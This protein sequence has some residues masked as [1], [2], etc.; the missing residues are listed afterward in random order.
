MSGFTADAATDSLDEYPFEWPVP[1]G[2]TEIPQW[3]GGCFRVGQRKMR[4]L[5]YLPH[6]VNDKGWNDEFAS[7]M[8]QEDSRQKSIAN[9]SRWNVITQLR[10]YLS[11]GQPVVLEVGCSSGLTL[12][13]IR[14]EFPD[15]LVVGTEY[16]HAA[17]L[18]AADNVDG[19]PLVAM[20]ITACPLP[21]GIADAVVMLN[22]LEHVEHDE[23]ALKQVHRLLKPGGILILEVPAGPD[24]YDGFDRSVG[25]WRRYAMG[26]LVGMCE[27]VGFSVEAKTHLGCLLYP[28]FWLSKKSNRRRLAEGRERQK[29]SVARVLKRGRQFSPLMRLMFSAEDFL[30]RFVYLPVG[31]RCQLVCAKPS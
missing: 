2:E 9:A 3:G 28:V 31:I 19:V 29:D 26:P 5:S 6:D 1:D 22:V 13:A 16:S 11:P 20:D 10:K 25:H 7:I 23:L 24:L 4:T 30:R 18:V 8:T 12:H 17:L 14:V 27:C 15:A 21:A